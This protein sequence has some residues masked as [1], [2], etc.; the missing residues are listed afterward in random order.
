MWIFQGVVQCES[1]FPWQKQKFVLAVCF[2]WYIE[3]HFSTPQSTWPEPS[4]VQSTVQFVTGGAPPLTNMLLS[5]SRCSRRLKHV[6][7]C[8]DA[9]RGLIVTLGRVAGGACKSSSSA[10][11]RLHIFLMT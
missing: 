1:V 5:L 11:V 3:R 10:T 8:S 4:P 9:T 2:Q 7:V 6:K